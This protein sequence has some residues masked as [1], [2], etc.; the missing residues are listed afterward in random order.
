M[1]RI[2]ER[3]GLYGGRTGLYKG[4]SAWRTG[5]YGYRVCILKGV[6]RPLRPKRGVH[7]EECIVGSVLGPIKT[8]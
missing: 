1:G 2:R 6:Q 5:A 4:V 3:T 7:G 8:V